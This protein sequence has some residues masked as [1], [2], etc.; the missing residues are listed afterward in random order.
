MAIA[1]LIYMVFT[2]YFYLK[3]VVPAIEVGSD[4]FLHFVGFF[5]G[6]FLFVILS[7]EEFSKELNRTFFSFLIVGPVILEF[8]QIFSPNRQFDILDMAF[9]YLGWTVPVVIFSLIG[10]IKTLSKG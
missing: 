7:G 5:A 2:V 1:A 8:L 4:K 6:G 9:N 10:R 3:P